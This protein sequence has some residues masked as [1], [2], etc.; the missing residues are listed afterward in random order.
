MTHV[1]EVPSTMDPIRVKAYLIAVAASTV[2]GRADE[3]LEAAK[4]WYD[5]VST[6]NNS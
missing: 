1:P 2:D 5:W 3:K 4:K 6:T